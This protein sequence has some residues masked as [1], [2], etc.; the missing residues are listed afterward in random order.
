MNPGTE[1]FLKVQLVWIGI[2]LVISL[3]L[4]VL[5]PF[6]LSLIAII[7]V[8]IGLIYYQRRKMLRNVGKYGSYMGFLGAKGSSGAVNFYCI[9]CTTKHREASCPKCGSKMKRADF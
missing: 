2:S 3:V 9:T 8:M 5:L 4:S 7:G 1:C 6:P